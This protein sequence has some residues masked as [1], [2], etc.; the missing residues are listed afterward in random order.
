[1]DSAEGAG[2]LELDA[3]G[4]RVGNK[5]K[6]GHTTVG[7]NIVDWTVFPMQLE[8]QVV[9]YFHIHFMHDNAIY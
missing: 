9:F 4:F 8:I 7:F 5:K 2:W 1:M 3:I 6:I